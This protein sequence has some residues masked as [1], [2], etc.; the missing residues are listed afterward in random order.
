MNK[1]VR[2]RIDLLKENNGYKTDGE[3]IAA[4]FHFKRKRGEVGKIPEY[5]YIDKNKGSFSQY[6]NGKRDFKPEDYLAIEYVLNTSMAYIIE[7]K[8][9]TPKDF[10]LKGIRYAAFTDT[11]GNYETLISEGT[12]NSSDEYNKMLIDYMMEYKSKNGFIFFAER[13]MLPLGPTGGH[14]VSANYLHYYPN[15]RKALLKILCEVLPIKLLMKYFNGFLEHH[16]I[17]F[18]QIDDNQNTSFTNDVIASAI[19]REDLRKEMAVSKIIN[20]DTYNR[21]VK[22][23]DGQS[24]GEGLFV[25]YGLTVMIKYALTHEIDDNIRNELISNAIKINSESFKVVSTFDEEELQI[26]KYGY[27]TNNFNYVFY[28]SVAIP[29]EATIEL[30]YHTQELLEKLNRQVCDFHEYIS[31]HSKISV[32]AN[33]ILADKNDN[34]EYYKFFKVMNDKKI[35]YIPLMIESK[36]KDKDSF[37]VSESDKSRISNGTEHDVSEILK[38]IR[39]FDEISMKELGDKTYYLVDPSIYMFED[40]VNYI[41]PKDVIVANKYSNLV[42]VLNANAMWTLC[43]VRNASRIKHFIGLIKIY[44]ITKSDLEEFI[45][46]F[47]TISEEQANSIDKT[48]ERGRELAF[49]TIKNKDWISIYREDIIKEF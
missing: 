1:G 6:F 47:I 8:G 32:F 31:N 12:I 33:I 41:M 40:H 24:F 29:C 21:G 3:V 34:K 19:N 45:D 49:N 44:G 37:E 46:D 18:S 16:S 13:D 22:R 9:D 36:S 26:D 10:E 15:D 27:I 42:R 35:K 30:P 2:E 39:D 23:N 43:E 48:S 4:I 28:G 11:V 20:L 14:S 7:G 38:T 25:N 5:A 17:V